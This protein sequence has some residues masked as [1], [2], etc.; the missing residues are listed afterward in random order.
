M[1]YLV[2]YNYFQ[3]TKD[4]SEWTGSQLVFEI[5]KKDDQTE[6]CFRHEGLVPEL[7]CYEICS[8]AWSQYVGESLLSLITTG[9]GQPITKEEDTNLKIVRQLEEKQ[10]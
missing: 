9:K 1:V 7:E 6:I 10:Q 2:K 3:F 5:S 4:R 8:K